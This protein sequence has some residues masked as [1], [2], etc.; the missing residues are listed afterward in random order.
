MSQFD[1][2]PNKAATQ[3]ANGF[4]ADSLHLEDVE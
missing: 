1:S 4:K 2:V 3:E